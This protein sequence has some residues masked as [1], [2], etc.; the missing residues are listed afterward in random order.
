MRF[1]SMMM[2]RTLDFEWVQDHWFNPKIDQI[3]GCKSTQKIKK[4]KTN[5]FIHHWMIIMYKHNNM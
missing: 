3:F 4:S 5:F 2:V 1:V